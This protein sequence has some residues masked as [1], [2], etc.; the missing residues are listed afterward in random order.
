MNSGRNRLHIFQPGTLL[1]RM[2]F[3]SVVIAPYVLTIVWQYFCAF[4]SQPLA[5]TLTV[6]VSAIVWAFYV[7]LAEVTSEK[8]PWQFWIV[9]ALPLLF[10][11]LIR[12]PFPDISFDVLN[13]HIFHGERALRGPLLIPGDFFPTA[14]PFNPTPD[15]LT[16]LYR[17][18]LGYR[19]GTIVN[20]IA[21]LWTGTI[22]NRLLRDWLLS[23]WLRCAAILFV[24]ATEQ[25]LFQINNYMVDLL[26]LP[27]LLEATVAAIRNTERDIIARRTMQLALLLGTAA[28]FKL[29]NLIF[30]VPIVLVY[31]FNV[32]ARASSGD[33][34]ASIR[35]LFRVGPVA[36]LA[37]VLPLLP[38]T[39][40]IYR[41]TGNPVF[42]L[43]NG[44][45]KS[46]YWPQG[47]LFDPRWGPYGFFET[48]G[49]P[50]IMCFRPWRLS[51]YGF[52]S[53]RLSI[54]FVAAGVL[55][56]L[57]RRSRK[58]WQ[59]A[60]ITLSAG[61]LWSAS[62]GYIRYA[63]YLELTSGIMLVWLVAYAWRKMRGCR[64]WVRLLA[65][66]PLSILLMGHAAIALG[67]GYRWE[68]SARPTIFDREK[69]PV[70]DESR[71]LLRDRSLST[72]LAPE[73][74]AVFEDVEVWIETTYKTSAIEALL[75]PKLPVVGVRM[76]E[77]FASSAARKQAAGVLQSHQSKRIFTLTDRENFEPARNELARRGFA[78]GNSHPVLVH[79][80]SSSL[81]FHLQLV[82]VVPGRSQNTE[83][84]HAA[85]KGA[86]LPDSAF[87]ARLSVAG[88]PSILPA[89]QK[90][91]IRVALKNESDV[92]WP[93]RQTTWQ[94]QLTV[95]DR[96][97]KQNGDKVNDLDGRVPLLEDLPPG[98]TIELP[99]TI[100]APGEA[101]IYIL[102]L[103]AIQE[104][105]AWFGDRGS[106]VLNLKI[107]IE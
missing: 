12:L 58:I 81:M 39:I 41:L 98:G 105:V 84:K 13:Y 30:A 3:A 104:G 61:I 86:A 80:F 29:A 9:V 59:I 42:P 50:V 85:E 48:L 46:P 71:N 4:H 101:G 37:S 68:W 5:W 69:P 87:N 102:Q 31:F 93:G 27:L 74:L 82:E 91:E 19:L 89:G 75:K 17:H 45:F 66:V 38:F 22:V 60:F 33:R 25:F 55:I 34:T 28:A 1:K 36:L 7:S 53:G 95:G 2:D 94:F 106:E 96:W 76:P 107:R 77:Y 83:N 72:Y 97:M 79:Y 92:T 103:D 16:G 8:L 64:V 90:Y 100:T 67:C 78:M 26:A 51:E 56:F 40:L 11:Y 20:Y 24:L 88:T 14:A 54:G 43:Y 65:W 21:L 32:I 57:P 49:W 23:R 70:L 6:L 35:R 15:I 44:L 63:L 62:S 52:Y 10:F 18:A 47:V 73:D 99:L